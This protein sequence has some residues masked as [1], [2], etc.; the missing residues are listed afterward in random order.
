M[1]KNNP[2]LIS[3]LQ[4]I[5]IRDANYRPTI[6]DCTLRFN[7]VR[8]LLFEELCVSVFISFF[9]SQILL[10]QNIKCVCVCVLIVTDCMCVCVCV[11]VDDRRKSKGSDN[12]NSHN[13]SAFVLDDPSTPPSA[14]RAYLAG[15]EQSGSTS[16]SMKSQ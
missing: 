12:E 7:Y 13:N 10:L 14:G 1:L 2:H 11:C 8:K 16:S 9:R 15:H 4:W 6:N 5:L 3:F